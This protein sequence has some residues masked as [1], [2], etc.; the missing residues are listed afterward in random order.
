MT[1]AGDRVSGVFVVDVEATAQTPSTGLMTEFAAVHLLSGSSF[2]AQLYRNAPSPE[3]PAL[4]VVETDAA[5]NPVVDAYWVARDRRR[6]TDPDPYWVGE[7]VPRSRWWGNE[8]TDGL[9]TW[10]GSFDVGRPVM[11]SDNNGFDAMWLNC[12]T[13]EAA[14]WLPFGHS[15]RRIG[16]FAAG[17]AGDWGRQSR[18]KSLRRTA[19]TH[20]P[21]DDAHGNAEALRSLLGLREDSDDYPL[22]RRLV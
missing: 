19:H 21:L 6:P 11:V 3:N 5:G 22:T 14:G 7:A 10:L 9:R 13:D 8:L 15:S 4:P 17:L 12:F 16:D 18:W 1:P 2:Y 20:N